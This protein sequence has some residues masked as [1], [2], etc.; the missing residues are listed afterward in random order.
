MV[1]H[2]TGHSIGHFEDGLSR[3]NVHKHIVMVSK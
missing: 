2:P 3:Q 1:Q